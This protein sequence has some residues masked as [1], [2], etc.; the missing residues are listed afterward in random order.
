M[1]KQEKMGKCS[2]LVLVCI[3]IICLHSTQLVGGKHA[4]HHG[5]S[6]RMLDKGIVDDVEAKIGSLLNAA[7]APVTSVVNGIKTDIANFAAKVENIGKSMLRLM[8]PTLTVLSDD[9][10][11]FLKIMVSWVTRY[12]K[13]GQASCSLNSFLASV[14]SYL[15]KLVGQN[16]QYEFC[17]VNELMGLRKLSHLSLS[18]K[19]ISLPAPK[20]VSFIEVGAESERGPIS[21][22]V[23]VTNTVSKLKLDQL[24]CNT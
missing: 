20:V 14:Q 23:N 16:F 4:K 24:D 2:R 11:E 15:T 18:L 1:R 6:S 8:P 17:L 3:V 13:S 10:K 5:R 7:I 21:N 9:A 12:P 22:H 19:R